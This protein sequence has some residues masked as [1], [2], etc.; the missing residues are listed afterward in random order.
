VSTNL[1]PVGE[2]GAS[3]FP[4]VKQFYADMNAAT[5]AG[6][7]DADP[8]N[9]GAPG[10]ALNAYLGMELIKQVAGDVK[11]ELTPKSFLAAM[12]K[13]TFDLA[14]VG[15]PTLDFSKPVPGKALQRLFNPMVTLYK[16]DPGKGEFVATDA[17][18]TNVLEA[19][20][21]LAKAAA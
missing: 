19:F 15:G 13:A 11:G 5:E 9:L 10:N 20:A 17:K 14:G 12:N 16:W 6:D 1:P 7:K 21:T 8:K 3:Q 18:P 2:K 4:L